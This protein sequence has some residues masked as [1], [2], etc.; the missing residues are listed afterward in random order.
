MLARGGT[1]ERASVDEAYVD[2]TERAR[3]VLAGT[4]WATILEK[5]RTSH[6]AGASAVRGKGYVSKEALRA[7]S[8]DGPV[9]GAGAVEETVENAAAGDA[10]V[11]NAAAAGDGDGRGGGEGRRRS[12]AKFS[13]A[14][15]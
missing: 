2:L 12:D 13:T 15:S 3:K 9:L 4:A 5:A 6:A 7:G 10:A 14:T 11:E 1:I 8:A